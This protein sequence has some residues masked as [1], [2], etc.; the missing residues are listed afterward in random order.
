MWKCIND[1]GGKAFTNTGQCPEGY[2]LSGENKNEHYSYEY[3][4]NKENVRKHDPELLRLR[5]AAEKRRLEDRIEYDKDIRHY[6]NKEAAEYSLYQNKQRLEKLLS[7]P[8]EYF[9]SRGGIKR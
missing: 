8:E 7:N 9:S 2:H 3:E 5:I 4:K 1:S 6:G